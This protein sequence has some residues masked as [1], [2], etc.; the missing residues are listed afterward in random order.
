MTEYSNAEFASR[1]DLWSDM[2]GMTQTE[3][4]ALSFGQRLARVDKNF[5][6]DAL[7]LAGAPDFRALWLS[8]GIL[9]VEFAGDPSETARLK[10]IWPSDEVI[11]AAVDAPV[12]FEEW[13]DENQREALYE[14][15]PLV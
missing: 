15:I 4:N 2:F 13:C 14:I 7:P 12:L 5:G 1:Y 9:M 8:P 10:L 3:F 11:S 6:M